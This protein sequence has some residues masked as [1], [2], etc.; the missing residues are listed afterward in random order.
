M[1][2]GAHSDSYTFDHSK[3]FTCRVIDDLNMTATL[4][5]RDVTNGPPVTDKIIVND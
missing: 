2:L 1:S 5:K 3:A 4:E